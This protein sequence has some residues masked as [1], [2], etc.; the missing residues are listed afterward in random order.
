M[1]LLLK[2]EAKIKLKKKEP[3]LTQVL[4]YRNFLHL[5]HNI[6]ASNNIHIPIILYYNDII[7]RLYYT[8]YLI[9]VL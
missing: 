2:V 6:N 9:I 7:Y 8:I 4:H 3:N 1:T 5:L